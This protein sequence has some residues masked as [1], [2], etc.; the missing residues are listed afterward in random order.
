MARV[1]NQA[2]PGPMKINPCPEI[3]PRLLTASLGATIADTDVRSVDD[4]QLAALKCSV[5]RH[6]VV[7]LRRQN[8][9]RHELATLAGRFG[10][11]TPSPLHQLLGLARTVTTIEDRADRPPAGFDWHTDQSWT[12]E[13][14]AFGFLH[15]LHVP[16]YGGDTIWTNQVAIADAV[17]AELRSR[18]FD[19]TVDHECDPT[20][21]ASIERHHGARIARRLLATHPPV[22]HPLMRRHPE[23]GENSMFLSPMYTRRLN[24]IDKHEADITIANFNMLLTDPHHQVRWRWR[25]GDLAIWDE[26]TTCHRA[27]T[28]HHPQRR[29]MQ[30][31]V[32]A[33]TA[34]LPATEAAPLPEPAS[35]PT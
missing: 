11:L 2:H 4:D 17:P 27:L 21:L 10:T 24:G 19:F 31:C 12:A 23:S 5:L 34:P 30:R 32:V 22:Q 16:A 7:F 20:L 14:P 29:L 3:E 6:R 1:S 28:D 18:C 26:R 8:L 15:A 33:G 25:A 35:P 13:P 9:D